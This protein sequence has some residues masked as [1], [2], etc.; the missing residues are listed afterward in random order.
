M[1]NH[2]FVAGTQSGKVDI[3]KKL[4]HVI[5][6]YP[7]SKVEKQTLNGDPAKVSS[8][9]STTDEANVSKEQK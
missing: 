1:K 3:D 8:D 2:I 5:K 6:T 9:N 4:P 7:G